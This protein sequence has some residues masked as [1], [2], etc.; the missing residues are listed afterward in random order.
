M[1]LVSITFSVTAQERPRKSSFDVEAIK[2]EK[3]EYLKKELSLTADE[4][5]AF[6]PLEAEFTEKKF[7][8]YRK[9]RMQTREIR[10]KKDKT[11]ADF[12]LI[13]KSK[14][15][16]EQQDSELQI[17]YF[18]KFSKVLPAEKVE[19]Y[20]SADLRF[21]EELLKRHRAMHHPER[22]NK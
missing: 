14:L 7:D 19:K 13:T 16:A 5:K 15:E 10:R 2:K 17:E 1:L 20:R 22:E 6:L 4:A 11:D 3:A 18:K 21:N 12:K 8:I 9:A